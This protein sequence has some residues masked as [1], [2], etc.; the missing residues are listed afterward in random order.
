MGQQSGAPV[1]ANTPPTTA[2]TLT[3]RCAKDFLVSAMVTDMG[4]RSYMKSTEGICIC[5]LCTTVSYSVTE[6]WCV[7]ILFPVPT[8][9][10]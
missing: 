2:H 5:P 4:D 8:D 7:F 9:S 6:Y 10:R 3:R 1:T